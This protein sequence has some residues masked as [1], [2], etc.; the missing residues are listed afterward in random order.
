M[1]LADAEAHLYERE[2]ESTIL[3]GFS[4]GAFGYF[5]RALLTKRALVLSY[6]GCLLLEGRRGGLKA[7][8]SHGQQSNYLELDESLLS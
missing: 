1:S 3:Y 8:R 6:Q 5:E 7:P 4:V 2:R